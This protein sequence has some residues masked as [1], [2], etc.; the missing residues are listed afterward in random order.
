MLRQQ[1]HVFQ[2]RKARRREGVGC[3]ERRPAW[4]KEEG[5]VPLQDKRLSGRDWTTQ[6]GGLGRLKGH[7]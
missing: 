4:D 1:G 2:R 6:S 3:G 7:A 5:L